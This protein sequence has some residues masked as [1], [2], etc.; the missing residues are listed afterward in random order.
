MST[1]KEKEKTKSNSDA[2]VFESNAQAR[3]EFL[4]LIK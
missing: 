4:A 1:K 2:G 3:A